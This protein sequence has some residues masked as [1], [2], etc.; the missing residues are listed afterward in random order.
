MDSALGEV[1]AFDGARC[2]RLV[3][4]VMRRGLAEGLANKA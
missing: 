4:H 1:F 3:E 2:D